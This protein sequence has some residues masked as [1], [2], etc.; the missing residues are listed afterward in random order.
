MLKVSQPKLKIKTTEVSTVTDLE[1]NDFFFLILNQMKRRKKISREGSGK[2]IS[3]TFEFQGM[4]KFPSGNIQ[5]V[6]GNAGK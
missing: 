4:L 1:N 2:R 3:W 6:I 5:K